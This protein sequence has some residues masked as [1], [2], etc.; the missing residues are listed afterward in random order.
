MQIWSLISNYFSCFCFLHSF[1][2][3]IHALSSF[4]L[5]SVQNVPKLLFWLIRLH[6]ALLAETMNTSGP[7]LFC[8]KLKYALPFSRGKTSLFTHNDRPTR[9]KDCQT[10]AKI[11]KVCACLYLLVLRVWWQHENREVT[12]FVGPQPLSP[13]YQPGS[14]QAGGLCFVWRPEQRWTGHELAENWL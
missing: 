13:H 2:L 4:H 3:I 5:S 1:Q 7:A 6:Q 9:S 12:L 14:F 10:N 11:N 8:Y